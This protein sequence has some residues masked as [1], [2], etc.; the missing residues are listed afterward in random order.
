MEEILFKD[1]K[2]ALTRSIKDD[3][4]GPPLV[5]VTKFDPRIPPLKRILMKH[6]D[7]VQNNEFLS[8]IFPNPP[9]ITY[10]RGTS[11]ADELVRSKLT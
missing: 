1:R 4:A 10:K 11:L 8:R 7:L 5:L 2:K 9:I 6:W 3:N